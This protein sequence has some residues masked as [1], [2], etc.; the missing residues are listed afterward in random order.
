M[1]KSA[2]QK[3]DGLDETEVHETPEFEDVL[4]GLTSLD[5]E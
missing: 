2:K 4:E 3:T 5:Q 1:G